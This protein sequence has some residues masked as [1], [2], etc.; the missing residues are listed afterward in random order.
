MR[1]AQSAA[2]R[3]RRPDV[4]ERV[5]DAPAHALALNA[6]G[7]VMARDV[8]AAIEAAVGPS[9]AATGVRQEKTAF[10]SS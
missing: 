8:E 5:V 10:P 3:W 4:L 9:S 7:T 1:G 2:P 6:S